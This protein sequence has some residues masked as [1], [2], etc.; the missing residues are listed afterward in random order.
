MKRVLGATTALTFLQVSLGAIA[1]IG[2]P[3]GRSLPDLKLA[4]SPSLFPQVRPPSLL[5]PLAFTFHRPGLPIPA[6]RDFF[7]PYRHPSFNSQRLDAQLQQYAELIAASGPPDILIVGSSRALQGVDPDALQ[8]ALAEQGHANLSV[9]NLSIN[10]ATA[11]VVDLLLQ[12]ILTP[13]QLPRLVVWA[14]GSRAFNSGRVDIT[15]N[16]IVASAGYQKLATGATPIRQMPQR[17]LEVA[18]PPLCQDLV[19]RLAAD[20][21][22]QATALVPQP[23]SFV[24]QMQQRTAASEMVHAAGF[25]SCTQPPAPIG[26]SDRPPDALAST[27][28]SP[29][30]AMPQPTAADGQLTASGFLPI[31][32]QFN[33]TTYYQEYPRVGGQYDSNYVPFQLEGMQSEATGAIAAFAQAQNIPLVFVNLPLTQDYLDPVRSRYEQ[34]FRQYMQQVAQQRGFLFRDLSQRWPTQND[35]FEDP[36]HL[37]RYGARAV[38]VELANDATIPW[39]RAVRS[40]LP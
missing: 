26:S 11:Q 40:T 14:D 25:V 21:E 38:A 18:P 22:R 2:L 37:N 30:D 39:P 5:A 9:F 32:T 15:Y 24:N 27:V 20:S 31:S 4:W 34:Q 13:Q 33:P 16:G 35:Y 12:R 19:P 7:P 10:G 1:A 3:G 6:P 8:T 17:E 28:G 36:S 23:T 29:S